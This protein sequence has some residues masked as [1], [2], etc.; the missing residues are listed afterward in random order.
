MKVAARFDH[1]LNYVRRLKWLLTLSYTLVSIA[2]VLLVTWWAFIAIS[3]Y[4]ASLE[5]NLSAFAILQQRL[6]P[7]LMIILP[8]MLLLVIPAAAVS[9]YFGF[10]TAR[11]IDNRLSNLR[12][13]TQAW[14]L[15]DF[16]VRVQD[17]LPDEIGN[18]GQDLNHMAREFESLLHAQQNLAALEERYRL[19]GDLHDSVK[20]HITAAMFQIG[21]AQALIESNPQAA[22]ASLQHAA[23]L[24]H[25]AQKEMS[26]IIFELRPA[27]LEGKGMVAALRKYVEEWSQQTGADAVLHVDGESV[28]PVEVER[29][30]FRFIQESLSNVARHSQSVTAVVRLDFRPSWLAVQIQD[31]GIGFS[32]DDVRDAGFGLKSMQ[33]RI[34]QLGGEL[35]IISSKGQGACVKARIPLEDRRR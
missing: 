5:S 11:W 15:G 26:A 17:D 20:Q 29:I 16:S 35:E 27:A 7:I 30:I 3:V 6:L 1:L 23:D 13:A 8:S 14:R 4:L 31:Q 25:A 19:A 18:F 24:T 2:A 32:V 10:L 12:A 21:A 9:T 28:L 33:S 22:Q 34:D